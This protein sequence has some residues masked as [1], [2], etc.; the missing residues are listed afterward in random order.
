MNRLLPLMLVI[1]GVLLWHAPPAIAGMLAPLDGDS[2]DAWIGS[3]P[4]DTTGLTEAALARLQNLSFFLMGFLVSALLIQWLWNWLRKDWTFLPKLTYRGSLGVVFLWGLVFVLILTMI[5][6]ARE[7]MTPGAWEKQGLT[8]RLAT[9]P[10]APPPTEP[11]TKKREDQLALIRA[12]LWK[13]A[14]QHQGEFPEDLATAGISKD[15]CCVPD[16]AGMTYLYVRGLK[17]GAGDTPLLF[18][19][20]V[21]PERLVLFANGLIRPMKNGELQAVLTTVSP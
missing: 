2:V 3:A 10:D 4:S 1:I 19:P 13:F 12:A 14:Q 18:E 21:F 17:P 16:A 20:D 6:G 8:Y 11:P 9:K 7:L 15:L 5:S